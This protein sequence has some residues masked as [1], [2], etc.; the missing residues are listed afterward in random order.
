M[1]SYRC[2]LGKRFHPDRSRVD[3][4]NQDR[5]SVR[6]E[7]DDQR[8]RC[9]RRRSPVSHYGILEPEGLAD[10]LAGGSEHLAVEVD[11]TSPPTMPELASHR[12][13]DGVSPRIP[14]PLMQIQ[15]A[16]RVRD[17]R[18]AEHLPDLFRL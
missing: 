7:R 13:R 18:R 4:H 9:S 1:A 10:V 3:L 5:L 17:H 16:H 15:V 11:L 12:A 2:S 8:G 14:D 6:G